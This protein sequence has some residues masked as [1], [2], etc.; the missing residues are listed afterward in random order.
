LQ[1]T[2]VSMNKISVYYNVIL[3][4]YSSICVC[5]REN[6]QAVYVFSFC[7]FCVIELSFLYPVA[8]RSNA[9]HGLLILEVSRSNTSTHHS[10]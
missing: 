1:L 9:G 10:R 6:F 3:R 8:L 7:A 4:Y 2:F 5:E